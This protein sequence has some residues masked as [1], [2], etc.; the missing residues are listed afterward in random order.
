[1]AGSERG[2]QELATELDYPMFIVTARADDE[3]S[4]CLIGF[5]TQT[6]VHPQRFLVCLSKRNHTHGVALRAS[7][8]AVHLVPDEATELAELFGGETGDEVDKLARCDWH[9]GP[10]GL[11]LLDD[12]PSRFVGRIL[13]RHD[14]GDHDAFLLDP[15]WAEHGGDGGELDFQDAKS[16]EP[17]HEP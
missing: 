7:H 5:S 13:W 15:V 2:F 9:E 8:L 10:H 6:S 14:A 4:G 11:P 1:V 12:A 17:G 16:I 3:R